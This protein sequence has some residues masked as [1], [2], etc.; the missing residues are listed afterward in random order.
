MLSP[1]AVQPGDLEMSFAQTPAESK[2]ED[3][4]FFLAHL[5]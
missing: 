5:N 1:A 4:V 3:R 2:A